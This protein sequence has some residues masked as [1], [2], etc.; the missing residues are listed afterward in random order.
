M[1]TDR[2]FTSEE[3][4]EQGKLTRDLVIEA[5]DNNDPESA[6]K[7]TRRMYA[8]FQ[9]MHDL[10]LHWITATLT[11][12]GE[13]YGDKALYDALKQGC[14]PWIGPFAKGYV[15]KDIKQQARML[16][17]G[18][19]G[20]LQPLKITEDDEK[21]TVLMT[22]CG[23][24]GRLVINGDYESCGYLKIKKPQLMTFNRPDFPVYCC[25]ELF[26]VLCA[27]EE[28]VPPFAVCEPSEN[29]GKE[30]C[31][32][33][34]YKRTEDIPEKIFAEAGVDKKEV[35]AKIKV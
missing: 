29:I 9:S 30:P 28:N 24:G 4:E 12:I 6:K 32:L 3:L 14:Q 35:L 19:R 33:L 18:L 34:L 17:M 8:E 26:M 23:S 20:H 16:F 25:H 22:P 13:K 31:R 7:L 27:V 10:Y 5:I 2:Y 15:G 1:S 11:H 21:F